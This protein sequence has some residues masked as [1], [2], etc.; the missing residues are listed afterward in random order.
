M[1]RCPLAVAA[2]F[3]AGVLV[4]TVA[5]GQVSSAATIHISGGVPALSDD[6]DAT[7]DRYRFSRH[8][9]FQG[10]LA[11]SRSLLY[12][13]SSNG[14]MQAFIAQHPGF[15]GGHS[16]PTPFRPVGWVYSNPRHQRVIIAED[17]DGN[18]Q[19]QLSLF[20]LAPA[21]TEA[22]PMVCGKTARSSGR[23]RAE[24]LAFTSTARERKDGDLYLI[25]PPDM[26]TGRLLK[27]ATGSLHGQNWSP[28]D[29]KLV[30][31]EHSPDRRGSRVHLIEG[32]D[33][34]V[35][36]LAPAAGAAG[37]CAAIRWSLDGRSLYWLTDR[38][39]D[40]FYLAKYDLATGT[41]TR[42]T[43]KKPWDVELL[44]VAD[45]DSAAVVVLNEDGL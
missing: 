31:V 4:P 15:P 22:S 26:S 21:A 45:D 44:S 12:L 19:F 38:D 25:K 33:R 20:D 5:R 27:E 14:T 3:L 8:A 39:S 2:V 24:M 13:A 40:F 32:C 30:V 34:P 7:V 6:F 17:L 36:N 11:E 29:R 23:D 41:D 18:E 37:C 28:D 9:D 10:W 16:S 43:E 1:S 42:L 35:R